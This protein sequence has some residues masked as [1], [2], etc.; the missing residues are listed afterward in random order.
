MKI[1]SLWFNIIAE[2]RVVS[3]D[4][5]KAGDQFYYYII[6]HLGPDRH[7]MGPF[8]MIDPSRTIIQ[9]E[10]GVS[11]NFTGLREKTQPIMLAQERERFEHIHETTTET[12]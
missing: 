11:M 8:K 4:D 1:Q 7:A 9:N 6:R 10:N 2:F 5:L 12:I 3:W